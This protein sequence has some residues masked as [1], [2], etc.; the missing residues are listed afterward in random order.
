MFS[1]STRNPKHNK[2]S[3]ATKYTKSN[4]FPKQTPSPTI[5]PFITMHQNTN[6]NNNGRNGYMTNGGGALRSDLTIPVMSHG[7][8]QD[9]LGNGQ[10]PGCCNDDGCLLRPINFSPGQLDYCTYCVP[11]SAVQPKEKKLKTLSKGAG[12]L[13]ASS[14]CRSKF[15]KVSD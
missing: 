1:S 6:Q 2:L 10:K 13:F 7:E 4:F 11:T 8:Q 9:V 5:N 14:C 15:D 3:V 12:F